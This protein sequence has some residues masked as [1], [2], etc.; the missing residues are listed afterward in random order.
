MTRFS[1]VVIS[2]FLG[3]IFYG[4]SIKVCQSQTFSMPGDGGRTV[5]SQVYDLAQRA[6]AYGN[7]SGALE[8]AQKE[9]KGCL[10]FGTQRWIDSAAAAAIVGECLFETGRYR[11]AVGFYNEAITHASSHGN[12][13]QDIRFPNQPLKARNERARQLWGPLPRNITL[14][15]LPSRLTIRLGTSDPQSVLQGGGVLSAPI[16]YPVRPHEIMR[17]LAISL[18]RRTDLL[19]P[20]AKDGKALENISSW[21][22]QRPAPQNHFSQAWIDV[23]LGIVYWSEAR[24]EQALPLL[25]R[26]SLLETQFDHSL[27][28]WALLVA[29][30]IAIDTGDLERATKVLEQ[31]AFA[32]AV[33]EDARALE[34]AFRWAANAHLALDGR[35]PQSVAAVIGWS[36]KQLPSLSLRLLSN[37]TAVLAEQGNIQQA[38][39]SAFKLNHLLENSELALGRCGAYFKYAGSLIAYSGGNNAQGDAEYAKALTLARGCSSTLFQTQLLTDAILRKESGYSDREASDLFKGLLTDPQSASVQT[40]PLDAIAVISTDRSSAFNAWL[41]VTQNIFLTNSRGDEAWLDAVEHDRRN[42]WLAN[43]PLGGRRDNLLHL[44]S[45]TSEISDEESTLRKKIL[46]HYPDVA[47]NLST[48]DAIRRSLKKSLLKSTGPPL[49]AEVSD[50]SKLWKEFATRNGIL[51]SQINF[52]AAGRNIFP[53][54]FPPLLETTA[55]RER[56]VNK[57]RLLTFTWTNAG[58]F[59]SLEASKQAASWR[60]KRPDEV[61]KTVIALAR[62]LS[63]YHPLRPV[64]TDRLDNN[65]W[66]H[67]VETLASL[68]F[69]DSTVSLHAHQEYDELI[70]VPDGLLWYLPFEL[71]PVGRKKTRTDD[72]AHLRLRDVCLLRYSPSRSLAVRPRQKSSAAYLTEVHAS[73]TYR[74]NASEQASALLARVQTALP[75]AL[76]LPAREANKPVGGSASLADNLL[77]FDELSMPGTSTNRPLI[78]THG[79]RPGMSFNEWLNAPAKTARCVVLTGMQTQASE[80][81]NKLSASPGNDLFMAAMDLVATGTETAILSRWNVGGRT[82]IDLGIEFIK[83]RQHEAQQDAPV[84]A[85]KSWQ[86]AVDLVTNEQPDFDRE[87]RIKVVDSVI[88]QNAKHPFFWA[89]YTL[90]DC[91]VIQPKPPKTGPEKELLSPNKIGPAE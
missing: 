55:V 41:A 71:L 77:I 31:A 64:E 72:D 83:D 42:R 46:A 6:L 56:L 86:R 62:S 2:A 27:T 70:I 19:G 14:S 57:Q 38:A 52:I 65:E 53:L 87:P 4:F 49:D 91:G 58:L 47:T 32:A 75:D 34:E 22:Q 28:P 29:G 3:L 21:L 67:D 51:Q 16:E 40:D 79:G 48:I 10:K 82:A 89:G 76:V 68:L 63:L 44:L 24:N 74:N 73:L 84:P 18:Y 5:P 23:C 80:G 36:E 1:N 43:R 61:R 25:N 69:E 26:G 30:R 66:R 50:T 54:Q 39:R 13:L 17:S 9:Y 35:L 15:D 37:T 81:L 85:T 11:E 33:Q 7:F 90:I 12:W 45:N 20:L 59:A 88:P 78:A 60:V 8:L